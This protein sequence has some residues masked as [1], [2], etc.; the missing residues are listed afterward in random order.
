[1]WN[2]TIVDNFIKTWPLKYIRV[3]V[4]LNNEIGM[5]IIIVYAYRGLLII[6]WHHM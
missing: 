2:N 3:F 1:M 5:T 4:V 6:S